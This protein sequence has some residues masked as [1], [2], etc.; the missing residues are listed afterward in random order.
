MKLKV[1]ILIKILAVLA[2]SAGRAYAADGDLVV[3]GNLCLGGKCTSALHV[4]GGVYGYC[5]ISTVYAAKTCNAKQPSS[6]I[7]SQ[8]QCPTGYTLVSTGS[9]SSYYGSSTTYMCFKD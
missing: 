5:A 4:S 8:C 9:S 6:C 2:F 3:N 7:N 1:S